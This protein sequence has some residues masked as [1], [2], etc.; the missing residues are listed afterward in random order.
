MLNAYY[1][2]QKKT[3][4]RK[5]AAA[6]ASAT[7]SPANAPPS[8]PAL[9]LHASPPVATPVDFT[10]AP[11]IQI[12]PGMGGG[13]QPL[14]MEHPAG[15]RK[16][17]TD[18]PSRARLPRNPTP[19]VPRRSPGSGCG[20]TQTFPP[21][22]APRPMSRLSRSRGTV[23]MLS[24]FATHR[25]GKPCRRPSTTSVGSSRT[26]RVTRATTIP[27][28]D[29]RTASRVRIR[30]GRLPAGGGRSAH[31]TSARF[32]GDG[33]STR[34]AWEARRPMRLAFAPPQRRPDR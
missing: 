12:L 2:S 14:P 4:T 20:P 19:R 28:I 34:S 30:T 6:T 21:T 16:S 9:S 17:G 31:Q 22:T 25:T 29:W 26:V 5:Q 27:P 11:W 1:Q 23:R 8:H 24:R 13:V 3:R 18:R 33:P 15:N 7:P 32:T 10:S